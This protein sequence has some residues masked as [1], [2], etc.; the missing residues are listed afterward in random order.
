MKKKQTS[1][2]NEKKV[3]KPES[4]WKKNL[5]EMQYHVL[6][7]KGT[8]R[9]F[10]VLAAQRRRHVRL[11]SLAGKSCSAP[12]QSSTLPAA[13]RVFGTP[14]TRTRLSSGTTTVTERN[15]P[16]CC[17]AA[18]AGTWDISLTMDRSP[19]ASVTVLTRQV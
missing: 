9:P 6:R 18:A 1:S 8:E 3:V 12:R 19:R 14:L 17:A 13:G 7:E 11:C 15:G 4:E 16:R 10:T 2:L 5:T